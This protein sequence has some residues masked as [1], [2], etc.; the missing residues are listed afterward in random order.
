MLR[1]LPLIFVLERTLDL[2]VKNAKIARCVH[3]NASWHSQLAA[4]VVD[5]ASVFVSV[6]CYGD[7]NV[8][9]CSHL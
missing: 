8:C 1:A 7:E 5:G 3:P 2:Q 6:G 9:Q 4:I